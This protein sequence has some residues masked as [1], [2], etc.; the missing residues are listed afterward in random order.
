MSDLIVGGNPETRANIMALQQVMIDAV[1]CGDIAPAD[2][3][4]THYHAPGLY[5]REMFIPAGVAV[6][7]KIH[8]HAHFNDISKGR[9]RV[10]TE[11]GFEVYEA[12]YRFISEPGTKRAVFAET[13]VVWTTFHPTNETDVDKIESEIIASSYDELNALPYTEIKGLIL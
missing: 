10:V 2:C 7:G 6:V 3:P 8:K 12:P 4:I 13:D 9:V 5:I 1:G 11:F